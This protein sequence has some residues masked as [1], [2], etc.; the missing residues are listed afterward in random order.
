[1]VNSNM[2]IFSSEKDVNGD[3]LWTW[4]YPS[5]SDE[6]RSLFMRKCCLTAGNENYTPFLFSQL[7]RKWYYIYTCHTAD[8][9]NLPQVVNMIIIS[10]LFSRGERGGTIM[11]DVFVLEIWKKLY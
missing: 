2:Y 7:D 10:T 5:V 6:Q 3:V 9:D 1:M 11:V 8:T 4:A